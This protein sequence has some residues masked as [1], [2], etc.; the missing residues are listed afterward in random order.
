MNDSHDASRPDTARRWA[1]D[2]LALM[3]GLL[4]VGVAL[5]FVGGLA[6]SGPANLS[7]FAGALAAVVAGVALSGST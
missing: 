4:A 3:W 1:A 7:A 5:F 2:P 6:S